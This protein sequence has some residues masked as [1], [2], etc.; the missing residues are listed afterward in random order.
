MKKEIVLAICLGL[1]LGLIVTYGVY[2]ARVS[3][4]EP[5]I[6]DSVFSSATPLPTTTE[7]AHNSITLLSP[8]DESVQDTAEVKVIGTTDPNAQVVIFVNDVPHILTS[9]TSGNFSITDTLKA[10]P[11]RITVQTI[12]EDGNTAQI[13]RVVTFST[14]DFDDQTVAST[15]AA[16]SPSAKPTATPKP[17]TS[18]GV[19]R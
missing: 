8:E 7:A 16:A 9:D 3:L 17:A 11:N 4:D 12:D 18:S 5:A 2:R 13:E 6:S 19:K 10:G 15:S 1:L 14:I